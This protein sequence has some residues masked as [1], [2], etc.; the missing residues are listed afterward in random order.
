MSLGRP[1]KYP[2]PVPASIGKAQAL[3]DARPYGV[4]DQVADLQDCVKH[5]LDIIGC[6]DK[7]ADA[8]AGSQIKNTPEF[9]RIAVA[10]KE[11]F[12]A[13]RNSP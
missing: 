9:L 1:G 5:L 8:V 3:L 10:L 2:K 12:D 13:R 11:Y 7:L 6:A 4:S